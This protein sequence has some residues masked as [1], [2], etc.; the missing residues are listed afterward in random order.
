M[1]RKAN[2][3]KKGTAMTLSRADG[4]GQREDGSGSLGRGGSLEAPDCSTRVLVPA[5]ATERHQDTMSHISL[6]QTGKV[7]TVSSLAVS[8]RDKRFHIMIPPLCPRHALP[9]SVPLSSDASLQPCLSDDAQ[10]R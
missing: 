4:D 3:K 2:R 9:T 1:V 5:S 7:S 10:R 6:A 8:F